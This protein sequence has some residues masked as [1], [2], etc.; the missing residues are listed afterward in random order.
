MSLQT[1]LF[2]VAR[3]G[4]NYKVS[5]ADIEAKLQGGDK[6]LV[7]RDGA[8]YWF[9]Y[10]GTFNEIRDSDLLLVWESNQSKHVTGAT[11][12]DLINNSD[13]PFDLEECKIAARDWYVK[14]CV[15][16]CESQYCKDRCYDLYIDRLKDCYDE[17]GQPYPDTWPPPSP[18]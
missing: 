1:A 13:P 9:G 7:Q 15:I 5:G 4:T 6:L 12:K 11:F 18:L 14:G 8:R 17:A 16:G 10:D 3:G 2:L